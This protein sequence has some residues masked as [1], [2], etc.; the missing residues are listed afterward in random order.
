MQHNF[1]FLCKKPVVHE[2][3]EEKNELLLKV[4]EQKILPESIDLIDKMPYV[5]NQ[6]DIGSCTANASLYCYKFVFKEIEPSRLYLYYKAR[7]LSNS[8]MY[9]NGSTI[10]DNMM[11]LKSNGVCEEKLYPYNVKKFTEKPSIECDIDAHKHKILLPKKIKQNLYDIQCALSNN[12]IIA[13]GLLVKQSIMNIDN[14]NYIY[15]PFASEQ[16]L[17]GHA[18]TICGYDNKTKLFKIRNSWGS[19]WGNSGNFYVPY[20]VILDKT[21]SFDFW[22]IEK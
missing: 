10:T 1:K 16:V 13:F 8:E 15:D 7:E 9:D 22:I 4:F 20:N 14:S 19:D 11:I 12:H 21:C 18:L 2:H 5:Y 17:G 6:L 3:E